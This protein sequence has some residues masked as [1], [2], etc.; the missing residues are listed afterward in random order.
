MTMIVFFFITFLVLLIL[1]LL[2][3]MA[4][5]K[6]SRN[7][8]AQMKQMDA[9]VSAG[10]AERESYDTTG[11]RTG[12]HGKVEVGEE[13][14]RWIHADKTEGLKG[15]KGPGGKRSAA[16]ERNPTDNDYNGVLRYDM[17]AKR[18]W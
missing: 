9:L 3:G 6:Y 14:Q 13:R 17:V 18:I 16:E 5:L 2:L 11:R 7:R 15:G 12:G 1:K 10:K 4:L 8:Y